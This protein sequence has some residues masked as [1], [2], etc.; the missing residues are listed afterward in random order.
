MAS[1]LTQLTEHSIIQFQAG[2]IPHVAECSANINPTVQSRPG[3]GCWCCCAWGLW[4]ALQGVPT[5]PPAPRVLCLLRALG[6]AGGGKWSGGGSPLCWEV[7]EGG[8]PPFLGAIWG[9]V[10]VW[11]VTPR[12]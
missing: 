9:D 1:E 4:G 11:C 12:H 7:M 5:G 6:Q 8:D 10:G 3:T 2:L